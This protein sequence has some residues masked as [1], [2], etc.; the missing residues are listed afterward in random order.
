MDVET[1]LLDQYVNGQIITEVL[2]DLSL[3]IGYGFIAMTVLIFIT[4]GIFKAFSFLR[5]L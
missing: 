3:Y 1:F 2:S 4:Y 5:E